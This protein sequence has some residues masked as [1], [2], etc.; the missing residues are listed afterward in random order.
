MFSM[1]KI[2]ARVY[3]LSRPGLHSNDR[4]AEEERNLLNRRVKK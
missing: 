2:E 3:R 4:P 1:P